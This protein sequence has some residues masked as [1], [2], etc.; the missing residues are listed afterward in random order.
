M[1]LTLTTTHQPATD[2]GFLLHK[3]PD[4]TQQFDLPFGRAHVFYPEAT[5]ERCT[6]ALLLDID[7][8]GLTRRAHKQRSDFALYPYVNDRPYVASSFMSVAIARVFGSALNGTSRARPDL[9]DLPL[10][11]EV[12]VAALP[13]RGGL[14]LLKRLFEPLGYDLETTGVPLD[15][16]FPEWGESS[17]FTVTLRHTLRLSQLLQHLYVMIPVLDDEKHYWVGDEELH[18]LLAK[19]EGWLSGHPEREGIIRR[20][21]RH[22]RSLTRLAAEH[23]AVAAEPLP[24]GQEPLQPEVAEPVGL[25]DARLDAAFSALKASGAARVLDLGCGE[26]K[27]IKRLLTDPQFDTV[28]GTDVSLRELGRARKRLRLDELPERVAGRVSLLH[29]S[30]L[31]RDPRLAGFDAA[32]LVE[33]IEHLESFRLATFERILFGYTRLKTVVLTTPNRDYNAVWPGLKDGLRHPDHRFEWTRAE[34]HGWAERVAGTYGYTAE[35]SGVGPEIAPYGQP[36][37][38]GVFREA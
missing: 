22:Q 3:H 6:A 16:S 19:G 25:H 17:I 34:F 11:L 35:V 18:K 32:A 29:A 7:P 21:L 30:L 1:L 5:K 14:S 36:S 26:G 24:L 23:L 9:V 33:V 2:L 31:Y 37:H 10:P 20:Y 38:L 13:C 27:L 12:T 28:V 15:E 8:V 4:K